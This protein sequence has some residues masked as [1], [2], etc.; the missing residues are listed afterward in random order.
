MEGDGHI[1]S[2]FQDTLTQ[3]IVNDKNGLVITCSEAS[4][5]SMQKQIQVHEM[6]GL[7]SIG[8]MK[9]HRGGT[10]DIIFDIED[11]NFIYSTGQDNMIRQWS[12]D[13]KEDSTSISQEGD[14]CLRRSH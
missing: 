13:T 14:S 7:V 2:S 9:G 10:T 3:V 4:D 5:L 11:S 6:E 8:S 12:V 1:V